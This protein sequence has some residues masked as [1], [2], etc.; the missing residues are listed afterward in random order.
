[1]LHYFHQENTFHQATEGQKDLYLM[2][3]TNFTE[4]VAKLRYVEICEHW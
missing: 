2:S 4:K 1:M 3:M